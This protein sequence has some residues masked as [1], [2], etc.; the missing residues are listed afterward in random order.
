[1]PDNLDWLGPVQQTISGPTAARS[2]HP[3]PGCGDHDSAS[4]VLP[5]KA[6]QS[7]NGSG[8]VVELSLYP[9]VF[10]GL[11]WQYGPEVDVRNA[12]WSSNQWNPKELPLR[13]HRSLASF[14]FPHSANSSNARAIE[15]PSDVGTLSGRVTFKPMYKPLRFVIR[16]FRH[17]MPARSSDSLTGDLPCGTVQGFHVPLL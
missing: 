6:W 14:A 13:M 7:E 9:S 8:A 4:L 5:P 1:M 2:C 16:F 15:N 3:H 12:P 10:P 11:P 17:P